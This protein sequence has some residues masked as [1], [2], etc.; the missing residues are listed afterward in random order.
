MDPD[1]RGEVSRWLRVEKY[2]VLN[3]NREKF[4]YIFLSFPVLGSLHKSAWGKPWPKDLDKEASE[5]RQ[6]DEESD[7]P[8]SKVCQGIL[9]P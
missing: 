4:L 2:W 8:K 9:S 3:Q 7:M 1:A 5:W 6:L